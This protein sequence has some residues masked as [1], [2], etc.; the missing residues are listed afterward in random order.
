M[1]A[2]HRG[3]TLGGGAGGDLCGLRFAVR[4]VKFPSMKWRSLRRVLERAP[5]GYEVVRRE[6]SHCTMKAEGRPT[7]HVAGHDGQ[8][9]PP[10]LV[11][12]ILVKDVGLSEDEAVGLL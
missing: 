3:V 1:S 6:G 8:T 11:R 12:K 10:G 7:I 2:C 5:L 4:M 9:F